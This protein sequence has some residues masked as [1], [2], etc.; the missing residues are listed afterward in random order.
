L[1]AGQLN[2]YLAR[3][4]CT[5]LVLILASVSAMVALVEYVEVLRRH[6]DE[7]GFTALGGLWLSILRVPML[8][9]TVLPFAFLFAALLS[10]LGLSRK[11]ELVVARAS[12]VSVWGFLKGPVVVAMLVGA[13]ASMLL[14]PLAVFASEV[15]AEVEAELSGSA[16]RD[17]GGR[18]FRQ[19]T[20]SGGSIVHSTSVAS[21][22][23]ALL[24]VTAFVFA[25]EGGFI[26]KVS[27]PRADFATDRWIL[28]DAVVVSAS[29]APR[30]VARYELATALNE[31]ELR[32]SVVSP[33]VVSIWS[34]PGFIDTAERTGLDVD[35]LRLAFHKLLNRPVFLVAMVMIAATV[36][37]RLTRYGG[38]TRLVLTGV[39]AGFLLYVLTEIVGDFGA[40]G[41]LNPVLAAWLPP[42]VALTFGATALL[43][44]E[45]G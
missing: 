26:E 33:D 37:L 9:D 22:G 2:R 21:S 31:D 28:S 44:Q 7:P 45:D 23:L 25:P 35:R 38:S 27:A 24:G 16:G 12:G 39:A 42:L 10:L 40:N 30:P 29:A 32:R 41:I 15:A 8:L 13:A 18:W 1:I 17:E 19:E 20:P 4:F 43:H 5:V 14:N 6:S 36:S 11:L 34:L 3:R